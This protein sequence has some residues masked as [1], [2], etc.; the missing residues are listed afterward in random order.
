MALALRVVIA[1]QPAEF[2]VVEERCLRCPGRL[3]RQPLADA[4]HAE[5]AVH[6]SKAQQPEQAVGVRA[7]ARACIGVITTDGIVAFE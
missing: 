4:T 2:V 7:C 6:G 5:Q 1:Q 3:S